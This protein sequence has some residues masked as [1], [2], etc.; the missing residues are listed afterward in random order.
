MNRLT[1]A[2]FCQCI[3]IFVDVSFFLKFFILLLPPNA[4]VSSIFQDGL[5]PFST[6][7][8]HSAIISLPKKTFLQEDTLCRKQRT[9]QYSRWAS[10]LIVPQLFSNCSSRDNPM[11]IRVYVSQ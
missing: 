2:I 11:C 8:T 7:S 3:C 6:H 9:F 1:I 4:S 10:D 5:Y